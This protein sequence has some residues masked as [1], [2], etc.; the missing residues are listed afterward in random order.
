MG[1][2]KSDFQIYYIIRFKLLAFNRKSQDIQRNRKYGPSKERKKINRKCPKKDLRADT[3]N[4]D[5]N[6]KDA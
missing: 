2:G 6:L 5:F 4:K 1:R 3:P